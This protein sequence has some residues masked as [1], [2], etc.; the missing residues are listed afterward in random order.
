MTEETRPA[1]PIEVTEYK[2]P[3]SGQYSM[4]IR[5]IVNVLSK[6]KN[7]DG[8][9]QWR[10]K[11]TADIWQGENESEKFVF[12]CNP[13]YTFGKNKSYLARWVMGAIGLDQAKGAKFTPSEWINRP[14]SVN[15]IQRT[16]QEGN[17]VAE[18]DS[19]A[20]PVKAHKPRTPQQDS[21]PF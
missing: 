18:V 12:Y 8:S 7:D 20:P 9:D 21:V 1:Q 4:E 13:N 3:D 17:L 14:L 2:L 11:F 16:N 5:E 15:I 19:F 6:F 10:L